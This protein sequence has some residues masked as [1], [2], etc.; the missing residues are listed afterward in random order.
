MSEL[1]V[2]LSKRGD[3]AILVD[4]KTEDVSNEVEELRKSIGELDAQLQTVKKSEQLALE[5]IKELE[6]ELKNLKT[7]EEVWK[8]EFFRIKTFINCGKV[9]LYS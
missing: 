2:E 1:E 9:K 5:K 6:R 4:V 7:L 3:N 8:K